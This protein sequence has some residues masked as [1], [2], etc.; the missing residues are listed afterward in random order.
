MGNTPGRAPPGDAPL[1]AAVGSHSLGGQWDRVMAASLDH[2]V[3]FHRPVRVDGW[4]LVDL[5][6]HGV[7]N[8]RGLAQARIFDRSGTHVASVAQEGLIRPRRLS[9]EPPA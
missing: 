4:L 7:A 8:A 5:E 1:G 3:W 6:G 2:A 9:A